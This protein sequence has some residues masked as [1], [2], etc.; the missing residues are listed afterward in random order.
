MADLI[1]LVIPPDQA[2]Y[3]VTDGSEVVSAQLDGGASRRRKDIIGATSTVNVSWTCN[4]AKYKYLRAFYKGV[5]EGGAT[6]FN[7]GLLLDE[8]EITKHKAHFVPGSMSLQSQTGQTYVVAAQLEV[9]P[10][11]VDPNALDFVT[12]YG[13]LGEDSAFLLNRIINVDYPSWLLNV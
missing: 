1:E 6:P 12:V 11:P 13:E 4:P 9:Y 7:I 3:A 2:G 8:P 5:A 10:L